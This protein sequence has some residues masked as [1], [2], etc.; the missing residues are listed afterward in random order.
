MLF[1]CQIDAAEE[2]FR[3]GGGFCW[4]RTRRGGVTQIAALSR[5][6]NLS[7]VTNLQCGAAGEF[8][9]ACEQPDNNLNDHQFT[10]RRGPEVQD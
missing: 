7:S 1:S 9:P 3:G 10:G 6:S 8:L 5:L 4:W 2:T